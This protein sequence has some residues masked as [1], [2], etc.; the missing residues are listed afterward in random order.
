MLIKIYS[1]N[2]LSDHLSNPDFFINSSKKN[3]DYKNRT[4]KLIDF[5]Y[6]ESLKNK[7]NNIYS[8]FCLQEVGILYQLDTL[9]IF[10]RSNRI[11]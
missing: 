10:F 8:I 1:Y 5:L 11:S 6:H 2:I 3:L 7:N 4:K 9:Y